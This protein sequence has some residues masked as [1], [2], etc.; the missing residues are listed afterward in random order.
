MENTVMD[1]VKDTIN[2]LFSDGEAQE[3]QA[4]VPEENIAEE[5]EE[6]DLQSLLEA[7]D[8]EIAAL[9]E[10]LKRVTADSENYRKR[11]D[12]NF[13]RRVENAKEEIFRSLLTVVDHLEMAVQ[14]ADKGSD[15]PALR[16][17]VELVL[18]D[19]LKMLEN[20]KISALETVGQ[21]FDPS[22][23]EAVM[24]EE[25]EDLPDDTVSMEFKKGY[26]MGDR[27]LRPSMVRVARQPK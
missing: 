21:P 17:G 18:R 13:E 9:Q 14:A 27:L 16:Q 1:M 4:D 5:A 24:V 15:L 26:K 22:C 11:L 25:R 3:P 6:A 2:K 7:K 12:A 10:Q 23:H 20:Y 19:A 8:A